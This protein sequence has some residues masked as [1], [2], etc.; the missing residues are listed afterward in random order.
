MSV[1]F[2]TTFVFKLAI[3]VCTPT[4]TPCNGDC[5]IFSKVSS[6]F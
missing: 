6:F 1:T 2:V 5:D 3:C 4:Y